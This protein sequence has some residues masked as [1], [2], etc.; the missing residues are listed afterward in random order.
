ME[1][2]DLD[3]YKCVNDNYIPLLLYIGLCVAGSYLIAYIYPF[4]LKYFIFVIA[5]FVY[6]GILYQAWR[7]RVCP[8]CR[9]QM[10]RFPQPLLFPRYYY[11]LKCK[12]KINTHVATN[13]MG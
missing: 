3:S 7:S 5:I 12:T 11:C 4:I 9:Q 2:K 1:K 6:I 10:I 13:N 8:N